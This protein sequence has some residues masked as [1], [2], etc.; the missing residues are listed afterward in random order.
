MR[1]NEV[2]LK[3]GSQK[4]SRWNGFLVFENKSWL[5]FFIWKEFAMPDKMPK[6]S[7]E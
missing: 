1:G 4:R 6:E 7:E 3:E 2:F 5:K